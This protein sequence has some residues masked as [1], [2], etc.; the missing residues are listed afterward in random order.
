MFIDI[1]DMSGSYIRNLAPKTIKNG[2]K[3]VLLCV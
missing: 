1:T 3:V 2:I